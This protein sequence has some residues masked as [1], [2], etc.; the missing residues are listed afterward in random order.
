MVGHESS[1]NSI[2]L[3]MNGKYMATGSDDKSCKVWNIENGNELITLF[4]HSE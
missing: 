1:V 3:S 4:G 2:A